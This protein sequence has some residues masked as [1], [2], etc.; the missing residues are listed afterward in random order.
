MSKS[1][2]WSILTPDGSAFWD[3]ENMRFGPPATRD[4]APDEDE[5]EDFWKTYYASTFNPARLKVKTMQGEMA[6]SYWKNL[7]EA[8]LI[9][10]LVAASSVRTEAMVA[11]PAPSPNAR[12]A[13]VVAPDL[14]AAVE[15]T[16]AA[17][18]RSVNAQIELLIRE[19]LAR[20]GVKL[21]DAARINRQEFIQEYQGYEL[22]PSWLDRMA[23]KA[24]RG[25]PPSGRAAR[26]SATPRRVS[27]PLRRRRCWGP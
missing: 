7:P 10:E 14:H 2:R 21:A 16:A 6:K 13:R 15:R 20:R 11:T 4:M 12:F 8:A 18:L 26:A 9:P 17:E 1:L 24:G 5:I 19:G 22:D 23:Q 3:G 27:I 25:L